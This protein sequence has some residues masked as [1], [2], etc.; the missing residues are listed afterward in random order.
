VSTSNTWGRK[1]GEGLSLYKT[2][3]KSEGFNCRGSLVSGR[4]LI[5]LC[6]VEEPGISG[7]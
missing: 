5:E 6:P 2:G 3:A 1:S 7:D 4:I